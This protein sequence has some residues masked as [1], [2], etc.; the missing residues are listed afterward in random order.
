M[1]RLM[2]SANVEEADRH[3]DDFIQATRASNEYDIEDEDNI[4]LKETALFQNLHKCVLKAGSKL[5]SKSHN[6]ISFKCDIPASSLS[7]GFF[8]H[9]TSTTGL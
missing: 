4:L 5:K 7:E 3:I 9:L 8:V 6:A 2:G 1:M